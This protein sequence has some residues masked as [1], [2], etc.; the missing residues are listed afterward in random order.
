MSVHPG[1]RAAASVAAVAV[2]QVVVGAV[3]VLVWYFSTVFAGTACAPNCD[4]A[5]ADRARIAFVAVVA[6]SFV[7]TVGAIVVAWRT[8]KELSC[9]PLATSGITIAGLMAF[10]A[11]FQAAMS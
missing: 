1:R 4:W 10:L 7:A 6:V 8:A 11:M 5:A 3:A 9:V 2:V